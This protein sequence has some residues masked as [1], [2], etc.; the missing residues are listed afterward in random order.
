MSSSALDNCRAEIQQLRNALKEALREKYE[1]A[2]CGLK[3]LEEKEGLQAKLDESEELLEQLRRELQLTQEKCDEQN[4]LHRKM[5]RAGF[6]EE[7]DLLSRSANREEQLSGRIK[8]LEHELKNTKAKYERQMAENDKL[9]QMMQESQ[10]KYDSVEKTRLELKQEIKAMKV[11]ETRLLSELDELESENLELQK[12]VLALKTSQIEFESLKHELKRGQE[13]N[14]LMHVQ[15]EEV[16]RLKRITEK[17]LEEA[18]ESLQ[19]EREQRHNL[20]KEL[21]SRLAY[22]SFYHLSS[23]QNG[24]AQSTQLQLFNTSESSEHSNSSVSIA[25]KGDDLYSELKLSESTQFKAQMTELQHKLEEAQRSAEVASSEV[26]SKQERI[27]Q[28]QNELDLI[29]GVQR[30]ADNEFES[31]AN[32]DGTDAAAATGGD[33][34]TAS[35]GLKRTL[36]QTETR[37][38]VALR[39]IASM[40]HELWRYQELEKVNADPALAD[41]DGLKAEV[42]RLRKELENRAEAIKHL[43]ER[44]DTGAEEAQQAGLKTAVV[45]VCLRRGFADLLK[46]YMLVC[47]ELKETPSKQV[48]E[49]AARASVSLDANASTDDSTASDPTADASTPGTAVST[50]APPA[51]QVSPEMLAKQVEDHIAILSHLRRA[52]QMYA[53]KNARLAQNATNG[54]SKRADETVEEL[55]TEI[56]QLRNKLVVKREQVVSL[57]NV[58]KKNKSVAETAL[59]NLKQKYENEKAIVTDT[60]RALRAELKMLKEDAFTYTSIRAMFTEKHEEFVQQMD[61]LQQKLNK[62]EEEKRTLNSILRLAIQQKLNLTQQLEA[63]EMERLTVNPASA[64]MAAEA[65]PVISKKYLFSLE[66]PLTRA[67]ENQ[68]CAAAQLDFSCNE[69]GCRRQAFHFQEPAEVVSNTGSDSRYSQ[70]RLYAGLDPTTGAATAAPIF[71]PVAAAAA[72]PQAAPQT[73][74]VSPP[75][76]APWLHAA[77][78]LHCPPHPATAAA[79]TA[80]SFAT[81]PSPRTPTTQPPV[82]PSPV[83]A[84]HLLKAN[85][86]NA[87][88]SMLVRPQVRPRRQQNEVE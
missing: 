45:S 71:T 73:P 34:D 20:K 54:T 36:R 2:Q 88:E 1:A 47:S 19:I 41:E 77:P 85:S 13:E 7:D 78:Q 70:M 14:D 49:L 44:I 84:P 4:E 33:E 53:E 30:R 17:S 63:I 66:S 51:E 76:T 9:H 68:H 3:L 48:C 83:T 21:D 82:F 52:V 31:N 79:T 58:L 67:F 24:L 80:F 37:Y 72:T 42:L 60:L 59:A 39:Q 35:A 64:R 22:E 43:E 28:L 81:A 12:N 87:V 50:P 11:V 56:L 86:N 40:Q 69:V 55:Q 61:Q 23:I 32:S 57:R 75:A 25:H 18:L 6:Q 15:L 65:A 62:A 29:M 38:S 8:D 10:A 74:M 5:S 16:T 46:L 26:N 27:N